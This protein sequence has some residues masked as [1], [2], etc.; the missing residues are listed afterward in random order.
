MFLRTSRQSCGGVA[1]GLLGPSSRKPS[2]VLT[3]TSHSLLSLLVNMLVRD[4]LCFV[5]STSWRT[6]GRSSTPRIAST[7]I[8]ATTTTPTFSTQTA[9]RMSSGSA[10]GTWPSPEAF[11]TLP[12]SARSK[13]FCDFGDEGKMTWKP[14]EEPPKVRNGD[15]ASPSLASLR[16]FYL[17]QYE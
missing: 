9:T 7:N 1:A 4:K 12:V 16:W 13:A 14:H 5:L 10:L 8:A 3:P 11:N 6:A 17:F 15:V 2:R